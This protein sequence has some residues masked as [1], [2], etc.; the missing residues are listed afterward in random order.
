MSR[1]LGVLVL[2]LVTLAGVE[3]GTMAL[4]RAGVLAVPRPHHGDTGFWWH[5]HPKWGAWHHPNQE[6]EHAQGCYRAAYRTNSV[7]ARDVE[8]P[9]EA[10]G[11]RVV[12][13]GDSFF[14]GY[15][16]NEPSRASNLLEEKTGI[17]HLNF[18]MASFG[19]Y[20]QYLVYR[21][22]AREFDHDAVV[23]MLLPENDFA[24][25]ELAE[26]LELGD[27]DYCYRPYL[28]GGPGAWER[29]DHREPALRRLLRLHSQAWNAVAAI[30]RGAA[31]EPDLERSFYWDHSEA[32]LARV[33]EIFGRLAE[34]VGERRLVVVLIPTARDMALYDV[35]GTSPLADALRP[36]ARREGFRLVDLLP[37]MTR[38]SRNWSGYSLSC[39]LHWSHFGNRVAA[40]L[41]HDALEGDVY[42]DAPDA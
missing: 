21:D 36:L 3:L 11:P 34:E 35:R 42:P 28:V 41:L 37:A 38:Y 1:L 33:V 6:G 10:T 13:L 14:E 8:R 29:E 32:Q 17:P 16:V 12:V 24:D 25:L 20:Q 26:C 31:P 4:V 19:P 40:E 7:G 39:D 18:A 22:L 27:T 30:R 15:G 23:A 9:R 5:A 2:V